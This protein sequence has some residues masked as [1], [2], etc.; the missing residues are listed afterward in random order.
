MPLAR[1]QIRNE[2]S[3][4]DPELYRASNK[5][6]PEALLEGVA[7]AG[8][9]GV[10][11]QL[12]DLAEFAAEIFHDLHEEVMSTAARGHG[13]MVRIRQLEAEFPSF[14]KPF[15]S[16]TDHSLFFANAGVDWHPNML[17]NII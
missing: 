1:Y 17:L 8:L 9:F 14:E 10:L 15:L 11:R 16:Q 3:L 6:D 7:M 5:D 13:L 12:G 4:A 2:Y